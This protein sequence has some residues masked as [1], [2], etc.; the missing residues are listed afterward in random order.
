M[1]DRPVVL[2]NHLLEPPGKITGI[3]RYLFSVLEEL[4]SGT[5]FK[6]VLATTWPRQDLPESLRNCPVVELTHRFIPSTPLNV[7]AQM[8][9]VPKLVHKTHAV[10]EFNCNPIGCFWPFWPRIITVHDLY[11]DSMPQQFPLR[12]R[13]WWHVIFPRALG[14][15]SAIICVSEASREHLR[16]LYPWAA[17]KAVVIHEAGALRSCDGGGMSDS[18]VLSMIERPY[19]L[20]VGNISRSKNIATLVE[21]LNILEQRGKS[22]PL[23]HVGRDELGLLADAQRRTYLRRPI[24][25]IGAVSDP[26]LAAIYK[27]AHCLVNTSLD[28]GFC[29]PVLEAQSRGTPVVCSDIPVLREVA[30]E[31]ALFFAPSNSVALAE[32]LAKIFAAGSLREQLSA[33][34]RRNAASFSWKRAAR[35]TEALFQNVIEQG[36]ARTRRTE[37][38]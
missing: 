12:H 3:T 2:I 20:Y 38:A 26:V 37:V 9:I 25:S 13:M 23:Y 21:A 29:L 27:D 30:G 4:A 14:A 36:R 32:S 33:L 28:E 8:A 6:Y 18:A 24:R 16:L 15:A 5:S 35:E 34:A 7:A 10:L 31:G 17:D 11:F 19:A 1:A 22:I